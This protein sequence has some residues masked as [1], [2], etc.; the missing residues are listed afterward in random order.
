MRQVSLDDTALVGGAECGD[1]TVSFGTGG[2]SVGMT[3]NDAWDCLVTGYNFVG[4][5]YNSYDA[6]STTGIPY[7]Y[8]HV[9]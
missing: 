6:H 2:I 4:D 3:L 1:I 5:M 9:G 7:G 8:A